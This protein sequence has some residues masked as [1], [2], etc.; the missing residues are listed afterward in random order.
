MKDSMKTRR[1]GVF[2]FLIVA[3]PG[4]GQLEIYLRPEHSSFVA[5]PA[6]PTKPDT[7]VLPMKDS[8]GELF[9]MKVTCFDKGGN[10]SSSGV[11]STGV[12]A[13]QCLYFSVET[14]Q[15]LDDFSRL[16]TDEDRRM[17]RNMFIS[18]LLNVSDQNCSTFLNRAFANKASFDT[19]KSMFQ[20]IMTGSSAAIANASPP[21]AAGL[22][23]GNLLVGKSVD[24]INATFYFDKTFQAM[25]AAIDVE[26]TN[27]L[28]D[29]GLLRPS[30][31]T[32]S[33]SPTSEANQNGNAQQPKSASQDT[34]GLPVGWRNAFRRPY[35]MYT[36]Y[37]ALADVRNYDDA[38]SIRRGLARLQLLAQD[39][40]GQAQNRLDLE[41][42]KNQANQATKDAEQ[43]KKEL[44]QS[45]KEADQAKKTAEEAKTAFE[46]IRKEADDVIAS[47]QR[48]IS[49]LNNELAKQKLNGTA[50]DQL[51]QK[52]KGTESELAV[53]K[54]KS[55]ATNPPTPIK[56]NLPTQDVGKP[57]GA[58]P[59]VP[60]K[61]EPQSGQEGSKTVVPSTNKQ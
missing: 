25:A 10:A 51:R 58:A 47:S 57:A 5:Q 45:K 35:D 20:D 37:D 53:L 33:S 31:K 4:C 16:S 29:A 55:A 40:K 7:H 34:K 12:E 42:T 9:E 44:D 54:Q 43:A 28:T 50:A 56:Q 22:S 13:T 30:D 2:V 52:L 23:L 60:A 39:L 17:L 46:M 27:V 61:A 6:S 26:R 48:K 19:G 3:L 49:E 15:M 1:R 11:T 41:A 32:A 59:T 8:K 14:K 38:C 21:A 18:Y 24:N 36:M